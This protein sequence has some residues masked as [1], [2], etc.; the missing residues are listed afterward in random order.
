MIAS[1]VEDARIVIGEDEG[2]V[3]VE[4][5]GGSAISARGTDGEP[6]A[7]ADVAALNRAILR[8]RVNH[9]RVVPIDS[10]DEAIA[11][12]DGD[13]VFVDGA[14]AVEANGRAAP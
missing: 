5:I 3:P 6:L 4:T 8:F 1:A 13:P 14:G 2:S 11:A 10:A 7:G 12:A 9:I